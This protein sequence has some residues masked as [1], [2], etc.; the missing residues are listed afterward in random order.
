MPDDKVI[1]PSKPRVVSEDDFK[2]VYEIDGLYPGYGHT[3]GNSLRRIIL[4]SLPGAAVT[5]VKIEGV[6]HEFSVIPGVKEDVIT[7][8]LNLKTVR[9]RMTGDDAQRVTLDV[10][11]IADVTAK[12]LKVPGQIEVANP[13]QH[14]ASLTDKTSK[15]SFELTIE[16]GI[17]YV[18]KEVIHQDKVDIGVIPV[19]AVFT[20]IRRANYEVENMRVGNRTDFNTLRIIIE[21][22]GI[23]TPREALE[24]SI[25]TMINQL[26]AIIGFSDKSEMESSLSADDTDGDTTT[27][28]TE[29]GRVEDVLKTRVEDLNFSMRTM[30]ALSQAGIRTIGGLARKS[31]IDLLDISGLGEKG[32]QEIKRILSNFGITLK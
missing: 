10:S 1:V 11:G 17:G 24:R 4:S 5:T 25:A 30:K 15:L 22:D 19:D 16:H 26:K 8:I 31:E 2:G 21:T 13:D 7:I 12:D 18:P 6:N 23:I 28:T 3:L 27:T 9:F 29:K 14:I 20:P 32:L